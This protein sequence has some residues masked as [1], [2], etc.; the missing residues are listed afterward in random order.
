MIISF[1][2][3]TDVFLQGR[4]TATRRH[5][6]DKYAQR[7]KPRMIVDA[8]DKNP[9]IGGKKI[10]Q[11]KVTKIYKQRL[12]DMTED[13]LTKEGGLLWD[14]LDDFVKMLGGEDKIVWVLEFE[15][16]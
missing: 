10:G 6:D 3:T 7:F 11:I 2:W 15:K 14:T 1:A 4:K 12:G 16:V 5:W 9:R 13:D 8:Y